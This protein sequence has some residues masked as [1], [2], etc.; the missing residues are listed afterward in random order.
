MHFYCIYPKSDVMLYLR[1]MLFEPLISRY[2]SALF[3]CILRA[4]QRHFLA[5]YHPVTFLSDFI[6]FPNSVFT[7]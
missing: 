4:R 3:T 7:V 1:N 2:R 5:L 6:H